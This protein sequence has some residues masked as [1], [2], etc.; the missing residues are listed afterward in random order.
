MFS[1]STV[2]SF[3]ANGICG[4]IVIISITV[5]SLR[6]LSQ[7]LCLGERA[8]LRSVP[9]YLFPFSLFPTYIGFCF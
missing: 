5:K 4:L 9:D 6:P 3:V 2:V 8:T 1:L 7:H